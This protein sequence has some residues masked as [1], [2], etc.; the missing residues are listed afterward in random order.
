MFFLRRPSDSTIRAYLAER[1]DGPFSYANVGCTRGE[2]RP[3]RGWNIDRE[4]VLLGHGEAVFRG[5]RAAIV[6]WQMFPRQV[7]ELCWP[8]APICAGSAVGVL[9]CAAPIRLWLLFAAK[10]VYV[11]EGSVE[12]SGG[13]VE[14]FGFAY[15]TLADHPERGEERFLVEWNKSDDSVWYD[16]LAVSQPAHWLTRLGYPY[17]RYEQARFRCLSG[18]AMQAAVRQGATHEIRP[19]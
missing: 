10:I 7:A 4:R 6:A 5:A 19:A 1:A 14:R 9:Y 13:Q 2:S 12:T 16:L 18:A 8:G 15:G 11:I 3:E 17:A